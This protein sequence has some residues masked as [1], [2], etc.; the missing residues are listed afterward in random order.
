MDL[1]MESYK[2][3]TTTQIPKITLI[4]MSM[5]YDSNVEFEPILWITL[6]AYLSELKAFDLVK[7]ADLF[8]WSL[9]PSDKSNQFSSPGPLGQFQPK[10][11]TTKNS[12]AKFAY[13]NYH[14]LKQGEITVK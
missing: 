7:V 2:M 8:Q 4:S 11:L 3:D 12:Y 10:L 13:L 5:R 6:L 14:S 1:M 9:N